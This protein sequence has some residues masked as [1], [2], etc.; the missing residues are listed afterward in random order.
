MKDGFNPPPVIT[1]G[2]PVAFPRLS[3]TWSQKCPTP[4]TSSRRSTKGLVGCHES[5]RKSLKAMSRHLRTHH[6]MCLKHH[7]PFC[8]KCGLSAR[9]L[10]ATVT[11]SPV[12]PGP[13]RWCNGSIF[14]SVRCS[15]GGSTSRTCFAP[16]FSALF[17]TSV[18]FCDNL[19]TIY[20]SNMSSKNWRI[21][22]PLERHR[23]QQIN[24]A[25]QDL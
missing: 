6:A 10:P 20:Q 11:T 14:C 18:T 8:A 23:L 2:D 12:P 4:A 21:T 13:S 24:L 1:E 5:S 16:L 22:Q 19:M 15:D 9:L 25:L 3:Y 17:A 7:R